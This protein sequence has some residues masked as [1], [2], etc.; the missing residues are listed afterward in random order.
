[1]NDRPRIVP[2]DSGYSGMIPGLLVTTADSL[3]VRLQVT[4][5][6]TTTLKAK[7]WRTG[8][9]EPATWALSATDSTPAL[10][11]PGYVGVNGYLSSSATT[12]PVVYSFDELFAGPAQ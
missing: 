9:M 8:T 6:G 1:M 4:G 12:T 5:T 2:N 7:I 11:S 10:Q 3:N